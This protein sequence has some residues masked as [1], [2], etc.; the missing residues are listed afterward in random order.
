N[1]DFVHNYISV[2]NNITR[3]RGTTPKSEAGRRK[4]R[5]TNELKTILQKQITAVKEEA[6]S[7]GWKKVPECVFIGE[8]GNRINY[9]N[10]LDRVWNY[11]MEKSK[12]SR[13][14]PHDMRH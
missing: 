11:C 6:L 13:R 1:I 4:V 5:L 12:L 9:G 3:G 2:R 10:F 14:T 8:T 7:K